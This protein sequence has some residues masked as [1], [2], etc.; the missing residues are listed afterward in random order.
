[1]PPLP[2]DL[3]VEMPGQIE[4]FETPFDTPGIPVAR[5]RFIYLGNRTQGRFSG[6]LPFDYDFAALGWRLADYLPMGY[7]NLDHLEKVRAF[8]P[9]PARA[10]GARTDRR[11]AVRPYRPTALGSRPEEGALYVVFREPLAVDWNRDVIGLSFSEKRATAQ[12]ERYAATYGRV[13]L[14]AL[15]IGRMTWH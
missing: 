12:A 5:C 4:P 7:T 10:A 2:A 1:M 6:L 3:F 9:D 11:R 15:L 8:H 14:V 13:A